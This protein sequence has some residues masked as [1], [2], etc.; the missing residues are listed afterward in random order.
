M[1]E[2]LLDECRGLREEAAEAE[3]GSEGKIHTGT[4]TQKSGPL[5]SFGIIRQLG[6]GQSLKHCC[7][8]RDRLR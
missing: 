7:C 6:R 5:K 8:R 2:A 3:D 4:T 1:Q